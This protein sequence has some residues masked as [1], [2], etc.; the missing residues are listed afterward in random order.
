MKRSQGFNSNY[1]PG[2]KEISRE[3]AMHE[4]GHATAIYLGNKQKGLPAVDFKIYINP[5]NS[6]LN[7]YTYKYTAK[8]AGGRLIHRLPYDFS[9]ATK[10][11]SVAHKSTYERALEADIFNIIIGSLAEA[12]YV[13]LRD[14]ETDNI[15]LVNINSLH[16]YGGSSDVEMINEYVGCYIENDDLR[17]NKIS[18]LFEA[19]YDFIS[20]Q[21]NWLA[22][23]DLAEAILA[24]KKNIIDYE[25]IID[26]LE[27][28]R[29][30]ASQQE[31]DIPDYCHPNPLKQALIELE[32]IRP[33]SH[34]HCY[35]EPSERILFEVAANEVGNSA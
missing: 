2:H 4:A 34:H 31:L 16:F 21:S 5:L 15:G 28:G 23:T 25:D 29:P 24:D 17:V 33:H 18:E 13:C 9:E 10:D 26:I 22:I 35:A 14:N 32:T 19:A 8:I 30:V 1:K 7:K 6:N 27:H 12:K 20:N 3:I 11:F